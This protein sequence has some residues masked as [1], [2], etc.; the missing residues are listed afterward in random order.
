MTAVNFKENRS[1]TRRKG[2][3]LS[4]TVSGPKNVNTDHKSKQTYLD[5][6]ADRAEGLI[7][8]MS[9]SEQSGILTQR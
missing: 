1:W 6:G 2:P 5:S 7:L 4:N 3:Q 9:E 8:Y